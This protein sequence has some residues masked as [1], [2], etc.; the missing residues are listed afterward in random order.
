MRKFRV[1]A[2]NS[3]WSQRRGV[4]SFKLRDRYCAGRRKTPHFT[5][6]TN[7]QLP[8]SGAAGCLNHVILF[9]SKSV[10][11]FAVVLFSCLGNGLGPFGVVEGIGV[12][13]GLQGNAGALAVIDA[14]LAGFVQEIAGIELDAGAVGIDCHGASG[15]GVL[16]NG[17]GIAE[18]LPVVVIAALE[19]Q[20][21]VVLVDVPADGLGTAEIH[22]AA[23]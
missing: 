6:H 2:K 12:E 16:K 8:Q 18:D 1:C 20:G 4:R 23:V 5:L 3:T 10:H 14:A 9:S 11:G 7:N 19:L 21:F 17:A 22:G 15:N 13:L